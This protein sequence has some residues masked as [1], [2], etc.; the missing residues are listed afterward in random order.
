MGLAGRR[1]EP[2]GAYQ[3]RAGGK[4]TSIPFSKKNF[5]SVKEKTARTA[6]RGTFRDC[7]LKVLNVKWTSSA[8]PLNLRLTERAG[9]QFIHGITDCVLNAGLRASEKAQT[10]MPGGVLD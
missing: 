2:H 1:Y 5:L 3:R 6:L 4:P 10:H 7:L 9:E 8:A